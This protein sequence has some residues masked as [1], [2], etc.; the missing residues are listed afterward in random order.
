[1]TSLGYGEASVS[2]S[3]EEVAPSE[4]TEKVYKTDIVGKPD[5]LYRKPGYNPL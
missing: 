1:M 5:Q 2:V 3:L 4:W